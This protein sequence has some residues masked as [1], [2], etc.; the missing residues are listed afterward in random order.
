MPEMTID[1]VWFG[2][3]KTGNVTFTA[4]PDKKIKVWANAPFRDQIVKGATA[5]ATFETVPAKG[6]YPEQ[7]FLKSW[8]G[9]QQ[10]QK[11]KGGGGGYKKSPEEILAEQKAIH[12]SVALQQAVTFES[13]KKSGDVIGTGKAF[14]DAMREWVK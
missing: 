8:G 11:P 5:E 12:A 6:D 4:A 7:K 2:D 10:E 1:T 3:G 13:G 9:V 14:Y